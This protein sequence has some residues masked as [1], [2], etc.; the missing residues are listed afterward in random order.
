MATQTVEEIL[1]AINEYAD[2]EE[3]ASV[4]RAK[5]YVTACRRFL[6]L[7]S[8]QSYQ[9]SSMGYT[10]QLIQAEMDVARRWIAANDT[11]SSNAGAGVRFLSARDGFRR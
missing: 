3:V 10:P 9:G 4:S 1:D 2:Y 6:Q 7:P 5:S 8:S 11:S